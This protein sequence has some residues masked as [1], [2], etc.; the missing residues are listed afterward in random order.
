MQE[1]VI[2]MT[3]VS[4][5]FPHYWETCVGSEHA[6]FALREDWRSQLKQ[7]REDIGFRYVRFHGLL[8]DDMSVYRKWREHP[9]EY[10]FHNIDLVFDY[11][12]EIGM[13]PFVELSFMPGE[14]ASG[15]KTVFHYKSN[16][17]PPRDYAAWGALIEKLTA[18]LVARYGIREVAAW[19]F[20]VWNEPN[21]ECFWTGS[22]EEYFMLYR[23]AVEAVKRV[24][25]RI[26]VG[27]PSTC[28]NG[29][30]PEMI[31]FCTD[32]NVPLDFI[33]THHYP[34][35]AALGIG[36]DMEEQMARSERG[37][38]RMMTLKAKEEAGQYP[39]YYT[40][41]SSSP[42]SRDPY[43]DSPYAAAF[44]IKT[45]A[46]NQGL[47]DLYSYWTFSDIFEECG[48]CS[49]PFHGGFGL[50]NI[51]GIPKP[52]YRAFELLHR[53]G[54]ER[55]AVMTEGE[56]TLEA[57][58]VKNGN[59]LTILLYN[60][61]IPLAPIRHKTARVILRNA[62]R[63]KAAVLERI[64]ETHA[65][66]VFTWRKMGSP[67][68]PDKMQIEE[69]KRSSLIAKEPLQVCYT[70]DG[71]FFEVVVPPHGVAAVTLDFDTA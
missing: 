19:F 61:H 11:L 54:E 66:P 27:G 65:N 26:P 2:N 1:F 8:N 71:P 51:H 17:T 49:K 28:K 21:L 7:C 22:M 42:G 47:V 24:D 43:H 59:Q 3:G 63:V 55:L 45:L 58:A 12:L 40:E 29:W 4:E 18:H 25:P 13:K 67:E 53:L 14:M 70:E 37:V 64:D 30:I 68:Y 60:H 48:F 9:A 38:L 57:L 39:L 56:S 15:S 34:T 16:V 6:A 10:S 36:L 5:A 20:E 52:A 33:S 41:W 44:L 32:H 62:G 23:Y 31:R 35:D 69:L 46:D 50:L